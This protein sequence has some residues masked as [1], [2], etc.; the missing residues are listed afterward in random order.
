MAGCCGSRVRGRRAP[1][2]PIGEQFEAGSLGRGGS[3]RR[4]SQ[5]RCTGSQAIEIRLCNTVVEG[6]MAE[7]KAERGIELEARA[8]RT[9]RDR[10]VI[11]AEKQ[12]RCATRRPPRREPLR[13]LPN[14]ASAAGRKPQ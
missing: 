13:V 4:D 11:D 8:Q 10:G 2:S 7:A 12:R 14:C 3:Q 1:G 6:A 5:A 9:D